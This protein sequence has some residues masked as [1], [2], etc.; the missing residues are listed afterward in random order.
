MKETFEKH[1]V[2]KVLS[3]ESIIFLVTPL[4]ALTLLRRPH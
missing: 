3:V 4:S 2:I 1:S